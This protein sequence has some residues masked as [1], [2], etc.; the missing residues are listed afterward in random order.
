[1]VYKLT[2]LRL[3]GC[4]IDLP[5]SKSLSNRLLLINVLSNNPLLPENLSDSDDTRA[6]IGALSADKRFIDVGA[7]GTAMRFLTAY[8][9]LKENKHSITGSERMKQRPI[10]LLVE[11]LRQLG[12]TITYTETEGFPPLEIMG[13]KLCGPR[14]DLPGNVSSQYISALMMIGPYVKGGLEIHLAGRIISRPYILMTLQTMTDFGIKCGW[15]GNVI[16]VSEGQYEMHPCRVE[17]DWTA[18]SYWYSIA[19]LSHGTTFEL[20]GLK[21]KSLQGDSALIRIGNK[22]GIKTWRTRNG[23]SICAEAQ[24]PE[25]FDFNFVN[26]PDL[27]Q[28]F[29]VLCCL[30]GIRFRFKGLTSLRIK[31]TDRIAA[32]ISECA[33]LGYVLESDQDDTLEWKGKRCRQ[34]QKPIRT[35]KD[36]RM[37]MAFAPAALAGRSILIDDPMVVTKSYPT[38]WNDL[39]KAGFGVE[40]E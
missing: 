40:K 33:K 25:R 24:I 11:A 35:F 17:A 31:E 38:F 18:A 19:A 7:A 5:A 10:A 9:A 4:A 36:H 37:A 13:G 21:M 27:A 23:I 6:M 20:C 39:E 22:L 14:I 3:D 30:Q 1:M 34:S 29:V 15:V 8:L 16:K 12:A 2:A 26:Q 32:L 28:T